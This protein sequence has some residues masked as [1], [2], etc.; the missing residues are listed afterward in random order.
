V[1]RLLLLLLVPASVGVTAQSFPNKDLQKLINV[2][3]NFA[4][5]ARKENTRRAFLAFLSDDAVV[6]EQGPVN[7]KKRWEERPTDDSKLDWDPEFADISVSGDLGY[8]TGPWEYR[9]HRTN[10]E[11]DAHGHFVSVWKK[12]PAGLFQNILDIGVNHPHD[13]ESHPLKT[14]II[15]A[16][17]GIDFHSRAVSIMDREQE[18]IAS[19]DK[20]GS[21]AHIAT[22]SREAR[23]YRTGKIPMTIP[24]LTRTVAERE[25]ATVRYHPIKGELSSSG[26]LGY[27]YGTASWNDGLENDAEVHANYTRIWKNEDGTHWKIVLEIISAK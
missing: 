24:S 11:P 19:L 2:E 17:A 6:F 12:T 20:G 9:I 22:L 13:P 1:K 4:T 23:L 16:K 18:F 10:K 8:T 7:G 5:L 27:V 14:S 15:H 3:R 25:G 26:D 21:K